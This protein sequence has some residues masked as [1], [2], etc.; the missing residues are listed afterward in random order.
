MYD[1]CGRSGC[2]DGETVAMAGGGGGGGGYRVKIY[3]FWR[4]RSSGLVVMTEDYL[5]WRGIGCGRK[6][7]GKYV[8]YS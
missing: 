5:W 8:G 4:G 1:C 3:L 2:C 7:F 6:L